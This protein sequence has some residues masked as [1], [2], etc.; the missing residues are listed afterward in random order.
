[1]KVFFLSALAAIGL[2]VGVGCTSPLPPFPTSSSTHSISMKPAG[3]TAP[4][5]L[6]HVLTSDYLLNA[7]A[8]TPFSTYAKYLTYAFVPIGLGGK[9]KSLGIKPIYHTNPLLPI[10]ISVNSDGS[11]SKG[12]IGFNYLRP[13]GSFTNIASRDC[14]GNIIEGYYG[15]TKRPLYQL[16]VLANLSAAQ[17]Y[18]N[19]AENANAA[20]IAQANPGVP[21]AYGYLFVDG[22]EPSIYGTTAQQCGMTQALYYRHAANILSGRFSTGPYIVNGLVAT[23]VANEQYKLAILKGSQVVGAEYE[24]C[25]GGNHWSPSWPKD[26]VADTLVHPVWTVAEYAEVHTIAAHKQFWCLQRM[27]GD[28][29]SY[30]PARLYTYASFLLT[31]DPSYGMYET[32]LST[33]SNLRVFPEQTVVPMHPVTTAS[34]VSG[35][36]QPGG[37]Y[38]REFY[39]CYIGGKFIGECEIVVNPSATAT[40]PVPSGWKSHLVLTGDGVLDGG[41]ATVVPGVPSSLGKTT[42]AIL[43]R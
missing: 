35:Y 40:T 5:G 28:G 27:T 26:W 10:C 30:I 31:Y 38:A 43:F 29:A 8:S 14:S 34:D 11:C 36:L 25:Y 1:M 37:E 7:T 13:G 19:D 9:V 21:H 16:D 17:S 18:F 4:P 22:V 23:K 24:L 20:N 32:E 42:A 15:V 33:P 41:K 3:A 12:D 6:S 39:F 2:V